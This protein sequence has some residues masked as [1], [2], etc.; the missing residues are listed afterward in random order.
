VEEQA[1][2]ECSQDVGDGGADDIA[3]GQSRTFLADCGNDDGKLETIVSPPLP[4]FDSSAT[5]LF[6]FCSRREQG[7]QRWRHAQSLGNHDGVVDETIRSPFQEEQR[8]DRGTYVEGKALPLHL[9]AVVL[10][11]HL[12]ELREKDSTSS[13]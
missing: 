12:S 11:W 13:S 5:H 4:M 2:R 8:R 10:S 1:E 9:R 7:D 6:P 3:Q